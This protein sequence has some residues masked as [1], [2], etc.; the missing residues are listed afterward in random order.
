MNIVSP[1]KTALE[2]GKIISDVAVGMRRD[3][4]HAALE[5]ADSDL[6]SVGDGIGQGGNPA[7]LG[8]G[9][10]DFYAGNFCRDV[11]VAAG[12]IAVPVRSQHSDD[13]CAVR[14]GRCDDRVGLGAIDD[15]A[16]FGGV[17]DDEIG[18]VVG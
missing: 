3:S 15:A 6:L 14:F 8:A 16:L 2:R 10:I 4:D 7:A 12:V 5:R 1:V 13:F 17:V 18:V 11:L 9:A